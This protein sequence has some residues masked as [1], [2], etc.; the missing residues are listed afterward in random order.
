MSGGRQR[1]L[2]QSWGNT[3][4]RSQDGRG[5]ETGP[6]A[7]PTPGDGFHDGEEEEDDEVLLV[8]VFE[9]E[10]SL[11]SPRPDSGSLQ[12]AS[13]PGFDLSSGDVWIYPNNYPIRPYQFDMARVALFQNTL[14]CLPT[15][16]GKTFIAAVVM[17]NFYRW[18]PS[19]KIVFMAPTKPLVAQQIE[20]CYKVM[21]IP[22]EHM[23]EM[24]GKTQALNRQNIWN[25]KRVVFLTPQVM[26][27]D[28]SREAC[29]AADVKCLVVDEAH[30][31][32]GNH[33]YCQVVREL[34][35]YTRQF[36]ILAL[37]ATPG[38]DVKAVQQVLSNLMI[39]HLEV[40][41]ENSLDLQPYS[42][43]RQVEKFVVPLGTELIAIQSLYLQVLESFT[44][45]LLKAG[46]LIHKDIANLTKYQI[47]LSREQFRKNPPANIMGAQRGMVE[48][49]YALCISLYHGYEL[50][51][52]MGMRSL[53]SY[54]EGILDGSKGMTRARNELC[55][56]TVF[57][58]LYE[59]LKAMFSNGSSLFHSQI[60]SENKKQLIYSHPKLQKLEEVVVGHFK[61][62]AESEGP[63]IS[64]GKNSGLNTRVM[65]F[66]SFRD[67]VQ[68]IAEM[69]SRHDPLVRVMTFVGHSS[70][71]NTKG[72]TQ[73]E[74]LEVMKRFREGGYNTLVSTCVGEEGL[75]IGE[76]DLIVCFDAQKSPIR[77]VQRMGRTGRKRQGRIVVLLAEGRE[78]RNYN[79]SQCSKRNI[80]KTIVG[81]GNK[82]FHLYC[83]SP[84]MIPD[85]INPV[86][87]KMHIT[88]GKYESSSVSNYSSKPGRK[89]NILLPESFTLHRNP[90][91]KQ[92]NPKEDGLLSPEEFEFWDRKFRLKSEDLGTPKFVSIPFE[93]VKDE[94]ITMERECGAI[95]EL[96]LSEWSLWQN[97]PFATYLI[98]HSDRCLHFIS[99]MDMID[100]MRQ[101]ENGDNYSLDIMPYLNMD[102][103]FEAPCMQQCQ[104]GDTY[105]AKNRDKHIV[106]Q[107]IKSRCDRRKCVEQNNNFC[108]LTNEAKLCDL[109][110]INKR[111]KG[112]H[113]PSCLRTTNTKETRETAFTVMGKTSKSSEQFYQS[114][115]EIKEDL[116]GEIQKA[117]KFSGADRRKILS[118]MKIYTS[119]TGSKSI[120]SEYKIVD[121]AEKEQTECHH[122]EP[123]NEYVLKDI[124]TETHD[125]VPK[126]NKSN[127]VSL[128]SSGSINEISTNCINLSKLFYLPDVLI[129][130]GHSSG[131]RSSNTDSQRYSCLPEVEH[132]N[133]DYGGQV[134]TSV[135]VVLERV[136]SFLATSPPR[137]DIFS[138]CEKVNYEENR[139]QSNILKIPPETTLKSDQGGNHVFSC[140]SSISIKPTDLETWREPEDLNCSPSWDDLF[141]SNVEEHLDQNYRAQSDV[142]QEELHDPLHKY[143]NSPDNNKNR[144][145]VIFKDSINDVLFVSEESLP[146]FEAEP[147]FGSLLSHRASNSKSCMIGK[148]VSGLTRQSTELNT[149]LQHAQAVPNNLRNHETEQDI[150]HWPV[151]HQSF[152]KQ[153]LCE[154]LCIEQHRSVVD[155]SNVYNCSGEIFS[156]NFDLGFSFE[157]LNENNSP[158]T[159]TVYKIT[160]L[161]EHLS[162]KSPS[163]NTDIIKTE[164][165]EC[166]PEFQK[167]CNKI[168]SEIFEAESK[169]IRDCSTPESGKHASLVPS[170]IEAL[171]L[172]N[173]CLASQ[174]STLFSPKYQSDLQVSSACS[175]AVASF[176]TPEKRSL[177]LN[178][179][180]PLFK[181]DL[182]INQQPALSVSEDSV[183]KRSLTE[184]AASSN[185]CA[186]THSACRSEKHE[187]KPLTNKKENTFSKSLEASINGGCNSESEDEVIR[188]PCKRIKVG[189]LE[190]PEVTLT[191]EL[192]SPILPNWK[193]RKMLNLGFTDSEDDDF[194]DPSNENNNGAKLF[195]NIHQSRRREHVA[196]QFLDEEA[197]LS[198][199]GAEY[200]SSDEDDCDNINDDSLKGFINDESQLSQVISDSDMQEIYLKSVRSPN[201][202]NKKKMVFSKNEMTIFSQIPEQDETYMEDSFC[203]R[204]EDEA[205]NQTE[206]SDDDIVNFDLLNDTPVE[207]NKQYAT[208]NR[209]REKNAEIKSGKRG[210]TKKKKGSRIILLNDSS[211]DEQDVNVN[212][213][214]PRKN[215]A[216]NNKSKQTAEEQTTS[217]S[218]NLTSVGDCFSECSPKMAVQ[219]PACVDGDRSN[220]LRFSLQ[221]SVSEAL[222]FQIQH[223]HLRRYSSAVASEIALNSMQGKGQDKCQVSKLHSINFMESA[224]FS[225]PNENLCKDILVSNQQS[226]S[227]GTVPLKVL[228]D[229]REISS[230]PNLVSCLRIKHGIK[231][232]ICNLSGCDYIVS[233]RMSVERKSFSEFANSTNRSKLVDRIQHLQAMFERVCIIVEKDGMKPGDIARIFPRT[234]YYDGLLTSLT[235]A[236]IRILFSSSQEETAGL[237][238][239]LA[240][241]EERKNAA[242]TVPLEVHGYWQQVLQFYLSIPDISYVTALNLCHWFNSVKEVANSSVDEIASRGKVSHRRAEEIYRYLHYVF[243]RQMVP[244][245]LRLSNQKQNVQP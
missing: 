85:G 104:V 123:V 90:V 236:G 173:I 80:Y 200:V 158:I 238:A 72:F 54:L 115:D 18:Y 42:H 130:R 163:D 82:S 91:I 241:V 211:E 133:Y 55:K 142:N 126:C 89:S 32:L 149:P 136:K 74:Q 73:K 110:D 108:K 79:Q 124:V 134:P 151:L 183:D 7:T 3:A 65:I 121:A 10:R 223:K 95:H 168:T 84:R 35:N 152:H 131:H 199:D 120:S 81:N 59:Q 64:E 233:N 68:E 144:T 203:V 197:E 201:I 244:D 102:D 63:N 157:D 100:L 132:P 242:I 98:D 153:M 190:S 14:V 86:A 204:E 148:N 230:G 176:T 214:L 13:L 127:C 38:S 60:G 225:R 162:G 33:A 29:P 180:G 209:T 155:N 83:N 206:L 220:A 219:Q 8:A 216:H 187:K 125:L 228:V 166:I 181:N 139:G 94:P 193:A 71:K 40:R 198:L 34:C 245:H 119:S 2:F 164:P 141:D 146:L 6:A 231:V 24:T 44:Q 9:A 101:E 222:D 129:T 45:R 170:K 111:T 191:Y 5:A 78:E 210:L 107:L 195:R 217:F 224:M 77:L 213:E 47:V 37:T 137:L 208:R 28:L 135:E 112:L 186:A 239:E 70:G 229:S 17:Y 177:P 11:G 202:Y 61:T 36:R 31:A 116:N 53:Y 22:Q 49:D 215:L 226:V 92:T 25:A 178:C 21:G 243:D 20:A 69:L 174:D 109:S 43:Q 207:K 30:K 147:S 160:E 114:E 179:V 234:R 194:K 50:L 67:S 96:S 138:F 52:Q 154:N 103:I 175:P 23:T 66:S 156:A 105:M 19:G 185:T 221:A 128:D 75:D 143:H 58:E 232:E 140:S 51:L 240:H 41:S 237:I 165:V 218:P 15:G 122:Y 48:G 87:H 184:L 167:N 62:W 4:P 169:V 46:A 118:P 196:R 57:K 106:H 1:T 172:T 145:S 189:V 93:F 39:S 161:S 235:V 99:I 205:D 12:P 188:R 171:H 76:V 212:H 117:A 159:N 113:S 16:L 27:N 88:T 97:R 150:N 192:N 26:M 227:R 56:N 182:I